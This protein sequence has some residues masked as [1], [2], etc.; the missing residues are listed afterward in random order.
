MARA[1]GPLEVLV[2]LLSAARDAGLAARGQLAARAARQLGIPAETAE[3]YLTEQVRYEFGAKEQ[4]G[5]R[6]FY[7]MAVA[8]GLAPEGLRLRMASPGGGEGP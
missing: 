7:R 8:E 1:D 6:A 4:S 2:E 5:V 3:R